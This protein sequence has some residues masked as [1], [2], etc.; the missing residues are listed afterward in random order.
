MRRNIR[1]NIRNSIGLGFLLMGALL[2]SC[3]KQTLES[4]TSAAISDGSLVIWWEQGYY[5]Q[6]DEAIETAI[7]KW[8]QETGHQV[9]L[10]FID[11]DTI[12]KETENAL[13]TG[14]PPDLMYSHRTEETLAPQWAKAGLL[15]DMSEVVDPLKSL[16]SPAATKSVSLYNGKTE[17][18]AT[19]AVPLNQETVHIHYSKTLLEKAGLSPADIP[20]DWTDFWAFWQQAQDNLRRQGDTSTYALGLPMSSEGHDTYNAFGQILEAYDIRLLDDQGNLKTDDPQVEKKVSE[21]L[22]WYTDFYKSGYVPPA[23]ADW[24][25]RDN[26]IAFLNQELLMVV[27]P[28][29]SIPASQREDEDIYYR[30][31]A[32]TRFPN[33]PDG[34]SPL[35]HVSIQQVVAF[36]DAP[37]TQL[38]KEFLAFLMQAENISPYLQGSLGR[39]FPVMPTLTESAFW[40]DPADPHIS[41]ATGQ[42]QSDKTYPQPHQLNP[43]Y[44]LV[45]SENV[46]GQA[47]EKIVTDQVSP[48]IAAVEALARI[49]EIFAEWEK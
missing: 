10:S 46:W 8:Q 15:A 49:E 23:A 35:Y 33:E 32:T 24:R 45:Q 41:V 39:Y 14:M 9:Q 19:Y 11:Q 29:L 44:G 22:A 26:N 6:E 12:L 13:K 37:N 1:K 25:N 21:A 38:A 17:Q 36:K 5:T 48:D 40:N 4:T 16:Y 3:S 43:A 28:T 42:F 20:T 34:E 30:Q 2:S 47:I 31:I 27:N 18:Y 7:E